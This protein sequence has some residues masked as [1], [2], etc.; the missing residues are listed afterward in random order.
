ML[1]YK[2]IA[3]NQCMPSAGLEIY[4]FRASVQLQAHSV[5][6]SNGL[7]FSNIFPIKFVLSQTPRDNIIHIK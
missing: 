2:A 3:N 6:S 1:E 4:W 7:N 5:L